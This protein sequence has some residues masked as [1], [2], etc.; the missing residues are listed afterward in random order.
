MGFAGPSARTFFKFLLENRSAGPVVVATV[1]RSTQVEAGQRFFSNL[2]RSHGPLAG[3]N[4]IRIHAQ[5]A[6]ESKLSRFVFLNND[7]QLG[8]A[9][10]FVEWIGP[11]QSL[12]VFGAGDDAVPLV[13][14]AAALGWNVSVA[15]GRP[16]YASVERFPEAQRVVVMANQDPLR[17]VVIDEDTVDPIMT[18]NYPLDGRLLPEIL[19]RKPCYVGMLGPRNRAEWLFNQLHLDPPAA[20]ALSIVAEVQAALKHRQGG[21]PR[22]RSGPIH[23]P[24][25]ESGYASSSLQGLAEGVRPAFCETTVQ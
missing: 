7:P 15:D 11:P 5:T 8:D 23:A 1:I 18:H 25:F 14:F 12:V 16:A 9:E 13:R 2:S 22:Q 21:K 6:L 19:R 4:Q 17:D 24:A 10:V 20:V 3:C